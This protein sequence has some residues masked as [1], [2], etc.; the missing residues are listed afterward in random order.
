MKKILLILLI[1]LLIPISTLSQTKYFSKIITIKE[2]GGIDRNPYF[3]DLFIEDEN[4]S[5]DDNIA[6]IDLSTQKEIPTY[7]IE[8]GD[9]KVK[10][11][12]ETNL[13]KNQE[14]NY[15]LRFGKDVKSSYGKSIDFTFPNFIGT[16]FYGISFEKIYI[17]GLK[18]SDVKVVNKEGKTLF[19]GKI[20][21]GQYKRLDLFSPQI[22]YIK[23]N[24]PIIVTVS[25]IGLPNNNV[26]E[27]KSDDDLTYLI[28]TETFFYTP[29]DIYLVSFSDSNSILIEDAGG[30]LIFKGNINK[31]EI[32]SKSLKNPSLIYLKSKEPVFLIY[33]VLNDSTFLPVIP[34][35]NLFY[36]IT[37]GDLKLFSFQNNLKY[38]L[39]L[40]NSNKS[41]D[42][43]L[44]QFEYKT[45]EGEIEPFEITINDNLLIYLLNNSSNF[46][47][48]QI[49]T[50]IG[51][52][53]GK[54]F[55]FITGKISTKYSTGHKRVVY[56]LSLFDNN[57][58]KIEDLTINKSLNITL[59]KMGVYQYE[60]ENSLS[61]INISS[62]YYI[63]VFETS[64]HINREIF[65]NIAPIKDD[66]ISITLGKTELISGGIKPPSNE[67]TPPTGLRPKVE[68]P[69]NLINLILWEI[70]LIKDRF[71]SFISNIFIILPFIK[72]ISISNIKFPSFLQRFFSYL[73]PFLQ[74]F[75]FIL[76]FLLIILI[77]I[78]VL[79]TIK[80][81]KKREKVPLEEV[82]EI[83]VEEKP[84]ESGVK[85]EEELKDESLES[86][87]EII[88]PIKLEESKKIPEKEEKLELTEIFHPEEKKELEEKIE[89]TELIPK[90]IIPEEKIKTVIP[91]VTKEEKY[92]DTSILKGKIVLD[93][94]ALMKILELDY[95]PFLEEAYITTKVANELPLK[96]RTSEKIKSV[97]LSKFEES[98]AEDLGKRVGGT[99]E[100]G[101]AIALALKL[102]IDKCLVGE[103]FNKVFQNINIYSYEYLG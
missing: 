74:G 52:P 35:K 1:T 66:S 36:G 72:N 37:F 48:E 80:S 101:E 61:K 86:K 99:K 60:T 44:N 71:K 40:I 82:E 75:N 49:L 6:L 103:K 50:K 87:S 77:L 81:K 28:G 4:L 2:N 70:S 26:F 39:N 12:F 98:M 38:K 53:L 10:F 54:E 23:S 55:S 24:G 85:R 43:L 34:Y 18:D 41:F 13:N 64:N 15:E 9:K 32:I 94:K 97:E 91:K 62:N 84:Y 21:Y 42:G 25:S 30:E 69:T 57:N 16:E 59:Q 93:R 67:T 56:V 79:I 65:F 58:V 20:K 8:K 29:K 45:F 46:G 22:F 51:N 31:G 78:L 68:T 96:Y 92:L 83:E 3:I 5:K 7:I 11:R 33:G 17:I 90:P 88:E 47:G 89:I 102:K 100:T 95:F 19:E 76:I 27:D 14:K 73:P 63:V